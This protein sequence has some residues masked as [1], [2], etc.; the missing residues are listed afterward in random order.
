[1][2]RGGASEVP[3]AERLGCASSGSLSL[4]ESLPFEGDS[5]DARFDRLAKL[6]VENFP[7]IFLLRLDVESNSPE[8]WALYKVR[9]PSKT[10]AS[11]TSFSLMERAFVSHFRGH[12]SML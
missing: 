9:F 10:R 7:R 12:L 11:T 5:L 3:S 6:A 1:M 4:E 8:W 2:F